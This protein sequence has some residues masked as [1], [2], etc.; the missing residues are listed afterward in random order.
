MKKLLVFIITGAV[1]AIILWFIAFQTILLDGMDRALSDGFFFLREPSVSEVIEGKRNTYVS[2]KVQ[3]AA[4]DETSLG[5]LGK[6]PWTRDVHARYLKNIQRFS[7]EMI[8]FDI[9]FVDPEK[10]PQFFIE[11]YSAKP[12]LLSEISGSFLDMDKI[13]ENELKK[14][15]NVL[16]DLILF[17]FERPGL[18]EEFLNRITATEKHMLNYS[19]PAAPDDLI[20]FK[21]LEPLVNGILKNSMP[22]TVSLWPDKDDKIRNF[23]LY[24]TYET[25]N[26][27]RLNMFSVVLAM[28]M[29]Y[30]SVSKD[31]VNI[32]KDSVTLNYAKVPYLN[33]D[34]S[35]KITETDFEALKKKIVKLHN[36]G[37][38][39]NKMLYNYCLNEYN[40]LYP[41]DEAKKPSLPVHLVKKENNTFELI[42]GREIY[43]AA[44][45]L[46]S[47][48]ID[49]IMYQEKNVVIKTLWKHHG[50]PNTFAINYAGRQDIQYL[51]PQTRQ[52]SKHST[53]P[54]ESYLSIYNIENLPE[55]P[56][57]DKNKISRFWNPK[58]EKW[59]RKLCLE[60]YNSVLV[61]CQ[62][63]YGEL[64]SENVMRYASED[65]PFNGQFLFYK[66]FFD[67]IDDLTARGEIARPEN[68]ADFTSL[69]PQWIEASGLPQP[70]DFF[71]SE[72][73]IF[74]ALQ[75]EYQKLIY[76]YYDKFIFTAAYS[77]GMADD[78][79]VTPYGTMFGINVIINA[80]NTIVTDNQLSFSPFWLNMLLIIIF[81]LGLSAVYGGLN[82][83]IN[84][85]IFIVSFVATFISSYLIFSS[86]NLYIKTV[87]V[88][89]AN[90]SIFVAV[91]VIK[92]LTEEKDKKFLKATFA[93]YL[94]PEL[95]DQM[96][97]SKQMPKLGGEA[98][99]RTAFFT[100]I[101]GFSTFSE[102]LSAEQLVE[103]LN[104]YLGSMT[105]IMLSEKGTLDKYIGDA[106]IGIFGAPAMISDHSYR[107][108]K[109]AVG[110]QRNLD[111]LRE[112][113][114]LEK[115]EPG[116]PRNVKNLPEPEW[117]PGA[118]WPRIVWDMRVRIGVNTGDMV[119]GN[120][121]STMRMNYTMMGDTVNLAARLEAGAKQFGVFTLVSESVLQHEW[122]DGQGVKHRSGDLVEARFIDRITV[123]GKSEPVEV[124]EVIALKGELTDKEQELF[125]L[126]AEGVK[127]YQD[128]K[129][130]QAL[131]IFIKTREM[132][133]YKNNKYT[134]SKMYIERCEAF[135]INP[136]VSQG[137]KWDG[138]FRMTQKH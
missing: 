113:W 66:M 122:E 111:R 95:I 54:M 124:Y 44:S 128:M 9:A 97:E 53:I 14:Y 105:D 114:K 138:V 123:V 118:K 17:S 106:I 72:K 119:T 91:T 26:K 86:F 75:E 132:E 52:L 36:P 35:I 2:D 38:G 8:H 18:P 70:K 49:I 71:L 60:R 6:W 73:H 116:R 110:M 90:V 137:E 43:D 76:K 48:K 22:V 67:G 11:K 34:N 59:F 39:Y 57:S 84:S 42:K 120:M 79:K 64:S 50:I 62:K 7:P 85:Y 94:A 33:T 96:Y 1:A 117:E 98:G 135:K 109:A 93:S 19:Q 69:Y 5:M 125:K 23:L 28:I 13:F 24:H 78:I 83:R 92:V 12:A 130:D 25:Q 126:F 61:S 29:K 3:L 81:T 37:S 56:S 10:V 77:T 99:V 45:A 133:I 47:K 89:M 108:L 104:E 31:Y 40:V 65:D 41:E 15:N 55:L 20:H 87:P 63:Q 27:E 82:V 74:T 88:L 107:A 51:D 101:Q 58:T 102:K 46:G 32:K 4:I 112:K 129:W 115:E 21:S 68:L 121:G 134:P 30:Y 80:F 127:C 136:P 131:E 16:V 103:L 100:D